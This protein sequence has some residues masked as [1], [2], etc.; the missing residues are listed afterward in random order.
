MH[1]VYQSD[2]TF[3][4]GYDTDYTAKT[5]N[6]EGTYV[7]PPEFDANF[8][9][10]DTTESNNSNG[11]IVKGSKYD[12]NVNAAAALKSKDIL[13][14]KGQR[15]FL[16]KLSKIP[17]RAVAKMMASKQDI[18]V[19]RKTGKTKGYFIYAANMINLNYSRCASLIPEDQSE[20]QSVKKV[21]YKVNLSKYDRIVGGKQFA[22]F[23]A[24]ANYLIIGLNMLIL[25][26]SNDGKR[27]SIGITV[28][29]QLVD[30][31]L[32]T[33]CT[34]AKSNVGWIKLIWPQGAQV[35]T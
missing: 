10:Y 9:V 29:H 12:L 26:F 14:N 11:E 19:D 4:D 8:A 34:L 35:K 30:N 32:C 27:V 21:H 6:S 22:L 33:G 16:P 7:L 1:T 18:V 17:V 13:R 28:D 20:D 23:D 5:Q 15:K 2:L 25:Y 31:R 3:D 24:E